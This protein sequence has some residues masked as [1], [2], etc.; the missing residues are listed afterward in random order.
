MIIFILSI[1]LFL[2]YDIVFMKENFVFIF[3]HIQEF[4]L[5]YMMIIQNKLVMIIQEVEKFMKTMLN[6][7]L[8]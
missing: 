1:A 3:V 7:Y 5:F 2:V 6:Q 4:N 8:N